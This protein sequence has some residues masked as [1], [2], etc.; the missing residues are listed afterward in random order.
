MLYFSP[1][2]PPAPLLQLDYLA[3]AVALEEISV[4][5]ASAGCIMSVSNSLYC[6]PVQKYATPEQKEEWLT[7]FASGEKL[8]SMCVCYSLIFFSGMHDARVCVRARARAR[9]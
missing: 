8:V 9:V 7:P 1:A 3:Y 2:D 5:C 4:G 6:G